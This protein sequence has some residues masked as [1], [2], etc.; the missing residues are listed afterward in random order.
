M[1]ALAPSWLPLIINMD[2]FSAYA[3][4]SMR[5]SHSSPARMDLRVVRTR[6]EE[7]APRYNPPPLPFFFLPPS[8]VDVERRAAFKD[9]AEEG[10]ALSERFWRR[11]GI[12]A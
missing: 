6:R 5:K 7:G 8:M 12:R 9:W 2:S 1:S 4:A 3:H 10:W 11:H